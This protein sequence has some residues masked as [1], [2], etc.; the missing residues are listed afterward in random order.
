M[1]MPEEFY[2]HR[3]I[4]RTPPNKLITDMAR[5]ASAYK[6]LSESL[7]AGDKSLVLTFPDVNEDDEGWNVLVYGV[8]DS[9]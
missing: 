9:E 4:I 5:A 3:T 8:G 1:H 2:S 6:V 7:Q